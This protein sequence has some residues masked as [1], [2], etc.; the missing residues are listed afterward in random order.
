MG[1]KLT[2]SHHCSGPAPPAPGVQQGEQESEALL[3]QLLELDDMRL[4][5]LHWLLGQQKLLDLL[6]LPALPQ[7][8][9]HPASPQTTA[10]LLQRCYHQD[11]TIRVLSA[12]LGLLPQLHQQGE[13]KHTLVPR[14]GLGRGPSP[15]PG[16]PKSLC[17]DPDPDPDLFQ[18]LG[19]DPD[20]ELVKNEHQELVQQ[21]EGL[22]QV[23][24]LGEVLD[25][26]P[27][28]VKNQRQE[29]VQ[30]VDRLEQVLD[31]LQQRGV[32]TTSNLEAILVF[33]LQQHRTRA[34]LDLLIQKGDQAQRLF[35][36]ALSQSEPFLLQMLAEAGPGL[37][38]FTDFLDQEELDLFHWA[39]RGHV[40]DDKVGE[41]AELP[42]G[43]AL[44]LLLKIVP[45][46]SVHLPKY[47]CQEVT[48]QRGRGWGE[49]P[50]IMDAEVKEVT[51]EV[52]EGG[53]VFRLRCQKPGV[54]RC[55]ATGLQLEGAGELVYG[56]RPWNL[57]FLKRRGLQPA[58]PLF[59]FTILSG[60][61]QR[62]HLPH[63]CLLTGGGGHFLSVAHVTDVGLE[64]LPPEQVTSSHV[65]VAPPGF[66]CFGLVQAVASRA[67]LRGL[68]LLFRQHSTRA[69]FVLLLPSNINL[70]QV[71]QECRQ[72]SGLEFVE[73]S[74]E[75]QLIPQQTYRLRASPG[76]AHIQPETCTFVNDCSYNHFLPSFHVLLP[77]GLSQLEL[78]LCSR[79]TSLPLIGW[80]LGDTEIWRRLVPL[81]GP[82]SSLET[83]DLQTTTM[84]LLGVL[85]QMTS[86]ELRLFHSLL[87][88]R[89]APVP[90]GRLEAA[91][92]SRTVDLL[93][94]QYQAGGAIQVAQEILEKMNLKLLASQLS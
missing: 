84:Q 79:S 86:D 35:L 52:T 22:E 87:S 3:S 8:W 54:F 28:L 36:Q 57:D 65:T 20:L 6:A 70:G 89:P 40:T 31:L 66:S 75:C 88:K 15:V 44:R 10:K 17:R 77:P 81:E 16:L 5:Q 64:L 85:D 93:L 94:Q 61:F 59:S 11:G 76:H 69:L 92:R 24:V 39:L 48:S 72:R 1:N 71:I 68:V 45:T 41:G 34:L 18:D 60:S 4:W 67:A 32:L 63:C 90:A 29:L 21:V 38:T 23:Q 49:R 58:G 73:T 43:E 47:D 14:P 82:D 25:V 91:D 33:G 55:S 2:D 50:I 46:L 27:D 12:G 56:P 30:Q 9:L 83:K 62:L 51:P 78:Q 37:K 7:H 80:L 42:R 53:D 26:D 13:A 19:T 74:G